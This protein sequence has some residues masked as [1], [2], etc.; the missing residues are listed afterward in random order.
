MHMI[1]MAQKLPNQTDTKPRP[2][3]YRECQIRQ[4]RRVTSELWE[5]KDKDGSFKKKLLESEKVRKRERQEGRR[6]GEEGR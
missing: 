4:K 5:T 6:E 2:R 1:R 3:M